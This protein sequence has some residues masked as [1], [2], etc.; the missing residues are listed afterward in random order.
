[1]PDNHDLVLLTGLSGFIAKH[2][3]HT[4]LNAGYRVRGTV[5]TRAKG[6]GARSALSR[7]GVDVSRLEI[8]ELDLSSDRGW[9]EAAEGCRYVQHTASPFPGAP[10]R[11]KFALVPVARDGTLRVVEAAKR[12]G[13]ERLVLTS[14][15]VAVY[16]GHEAKG[17]TFTEADVSNVQS[18]SISSYAVSKTLAEQAAWEAVASHPMEMAVLNPALVLGPAL[19]AETGTSLSIIA[20]MMKGMMP[21]VPTA[22]FGVVDVRDVAEAHRRAMVLPDA[23]GRRF[24]LSGGHRTLLEIGAAVRAAY[25]RLRRLPR[26]EIP[27]ALVILAGKISTRAALLQ[28]E[29]DPARV[30]DNSAARTVLGLEFRDPD[31]AVESAARS[32]VTFGLV[33]A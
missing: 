14:S 17:R 5:R 12:A 24:I 26:H 20:M 13:V 10:P 15:V 3:A 31:V 27:N 11:D 6:E 23:V 9:A 25:P 30:L 32:L 4:L 7:S 1:M 22:R 33:Q 29:L 28:N 18:D 2:V 16:H 19:D 8:V 21:L